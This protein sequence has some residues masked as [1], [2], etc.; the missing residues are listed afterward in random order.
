MSIGVAAPLLGALGQ[1]SGVIALGYLLRRFNII[2]YSDTGAIKKFCGRVALPAI[3]F[4]EIARIDWGVVDWA[5][6]LGMFAAKVAVFVIVAVLL[7]ARAGCSTS[8]AHCN[9]VRRRRNKIAS[10]VVGIEG[11]GGAE[12][13]PTPSCDPDLLGTIGLFCIMATKSN[14]IALGVPV[15]NAIWPSASSSSSSSDGSGAAPAGPSS[16]A[17]ATP[18]ATYLYL[19]AP[20][21]LIIL[22]VLGFVMM[23]LN[24]RRRKDRVAAAARAALGEATPPAEPRA[25]GALRDAITPIPRVV[26]NVITTPPVLSVLFGLATNVV[27]TC[28]GTAMPTVVVDGLEIIGNGYTVT[29]LLSIGFG[30]FGSLERNVRFTPKQYADGALLLFFKIGALAFAT[31]LTVKL[32]SAGKPAAEQERAAE[33]GWLYGMVPVAPT[34]YIFAEMYEIHADFTAV[35]YVAC[36]PYY[37]E[38]YGIVTTVLHFVGIRLTI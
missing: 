4:T 31:N 28:T 11:E 37:L 25:C 18:F 13:E 30:V 7:L 24:L 19:F 15:V 38:V 26:W 20:F 21:Q 3:F 16:G 14:D 22:N 9:A 5:I 10:G 23:E 12:T 34:V 36:N 27:L 33:F 1:T 29:A 35:M 2:T 6:L 32:F 8:V 17:S